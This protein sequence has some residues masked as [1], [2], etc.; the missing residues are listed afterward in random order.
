MFIKELGQNAIQS[1]AKNP[2]AAITTGII[3]G[4]YV[5]TIAAGV[6]AGAAI[7]VGLAKLFKS[8]GSGGRGSAPAAGVI[9]Y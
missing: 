3:A 2:K 1:V 8:S 9:T 4:P 5:L 6:I 7:G